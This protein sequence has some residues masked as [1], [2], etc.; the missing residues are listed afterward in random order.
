MQRKVLCEIIESRMRELAVMVKQ[1]IEKSGMVGM[2]PG[3]VVLTGGGSRLEGTDKLFEDVLKHLRVRVAEPKLPSTFQSEVD[4]YGLATAYG[5]AQFALQCHDDDL[6]P[7]SGSEH[8][9]DR[10]RTVWSVLSGR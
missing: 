10:I 3:G 8:W 7:A 2:L 9:K 6:A 5:M 1:Q 4:P